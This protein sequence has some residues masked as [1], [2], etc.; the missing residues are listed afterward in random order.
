MG[1]QV[2]GDNGGIAGL[3]GFIREHREALEYHLIKLGLRLRDLGTEKLS[4][5]D[6]KIIVRHIEPGSP[7]HHAIAPEQARWATG[8][9]VPY[10]LAHIADVLA[11]A[12]WQRANRPSAPRPK[13]IPR[14]GD[15]AQNKKYGSEPIPVSSFNDWWESGTKER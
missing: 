4:W 7:L 12:N 5:Y 2:S 15:N 11:N 10:L 9:I 3:I 13:P 6:L 8:E 1:A 14:P